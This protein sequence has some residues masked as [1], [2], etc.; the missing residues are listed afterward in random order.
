MAYEKQTWNTSS[1][2]N[3]TRMN[4][5]EDGIADIKEGTILTLEPT[6]NETYASM[7]ARFRTTS[8]CLTNG[9]Y[10]YYILRFRPAGAS[11]SSNLIFVPTRYV[12]NSV[13][14]YTS[15]RVTDTAIVFYNLQ[16]STNNVILRQ[17]MIDSNCASITYAS[18]NTAQSGVRVMGLNNNE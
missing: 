3:P 13:V 2:F 1:I 4:H 18:N 5:I 17:V 7:F 16:I 11:S 12:G 9:S 14:E 15:C 10:N 8:G 6:S